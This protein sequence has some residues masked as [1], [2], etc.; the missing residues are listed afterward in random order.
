M[1]AMGVVEDDTK[2][3]QSAGKMSMPIGSNPP[4]AQIGFFGVLS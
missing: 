4:T 1:L 2:T 3:G